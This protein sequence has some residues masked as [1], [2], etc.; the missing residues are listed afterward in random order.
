MPEV[1]AFRGLR[2]NPDRVGALDN[3]VTPPWDVI[4]PAQREE[5]VGRT[6]HNMARVLLPAEEDGL[7]PPQAAGRALK[8]W[9][10]EGALARDGAEAFYLIEQ[11]F[12][13]LEGQRRRRRGFF[14]I[15]RIPEPGE[16]IVLGHERTFAKNVDNRLALMQTTQANLGAIFVLY[17]DPDH[18]LGAFLEHM[19]EREPDA[20]AHTFDG[21]AQ[22]LWRVPADPAV[23]AFMADKKLYIAD[24]HHRFHTACVYRDA[25]RAQYPD[26]GPQ[27][28]DYVL[29]GF[30]A[31]DEPGL[32]IYP[33][34]RLLP[35]P[36]GFDDAGLIKRLAPWFDAAPVDGDLPARLMETPGCAFGLVSA[37]G[38]RH[39]LTLRPEHTPSA[40]VGDAYGP[41][42]R[43]LDVAVLHQGIL[44][45]ALGLAG[46]TEYT[47]EQVAAR[48]VERVAA[49]EHRLG[50]LLKG[51]RPNELRACAESGDPMPQKSTYFF[52]KLPSG[53]VIHAWDTASAS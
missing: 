31:F 1:R 11:E 10:E 39:L 2:Y 27:P 17:N 38:G 26:A 51:I 49:G 23:T 22:R 21:V 48:A 13:D 47:Y 25:M 7:A 16:R 24:G 52:P 41:A 32:L 34:H 18:A 4:S 8:Q 28:Y 5:L 44:E 19:D 36:N 29:M 35:M 37:E 50:F 12:E 6:P 45:G 42:V 53:M 3:V 43:E 9:V 15:T 46:D 30:V 14:G 33:P 40:L 20:L